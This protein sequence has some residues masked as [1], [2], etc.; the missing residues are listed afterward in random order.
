MNDTSSTSL[1]NV[2]PA[3]RRAL[4]NPWLMVVMLFFVT[5]AFGI[6]FLW[7]SRGFSKTA[8]VVLTIVVLLYTVLILWAFTLFMI[9]W[10]TNFIAP[11][12]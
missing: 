3:W 6:P 8:K 7:L 2:S 4:D 5:A 10:W 11:Y 12:L 9:Y 1:P